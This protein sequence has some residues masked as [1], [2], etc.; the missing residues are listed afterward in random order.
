MVSCEKVIIKQ[1]TEKAGKNLSVLYF[2]WIL[3]KEITSHCMDH[4]LYTY[5]LRCRR[6]SQ[7]IINFED[8]EMKETVAPV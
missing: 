7:K 4:F 2:Q 5:L 8:T 6:V 3:R 1:L